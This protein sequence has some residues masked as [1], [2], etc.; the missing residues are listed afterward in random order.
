MATWQVLD[1]LGG[2]ISCGHMV[3]EALDPH[4]SE[5]GLTEE[6][7]ILLDRA[8]LAG[9]KF[10]FPSPVWGVRCVSAML[11]HARRRNPECQLKSAR[12]ALICGS[13][14]VLAPPPQS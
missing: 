10:W 13:L 9:E 5:P 2:G 12:A 11:K 1:L 8:C 7:K 6:L 3:K 14:P 4:N